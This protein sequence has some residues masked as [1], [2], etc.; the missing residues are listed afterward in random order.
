M[1][2]YPQEFRTQ[3]VISFMVIA[4]IGLVAG[5]DIL[6]SAIGIGQVI[7]STRIF[8]LH[9]GKPVSV[10]LAIQSITLIFKFLLFLASGILFLVWLNRANKNLASLQPLHVEFSSGWAVGWW[11]VPF[12]A[13][14]K[15][16]QVVRE[17]W[18]ESDPDRSGEQ[19]FLTSNLHSAPAYMG[20]WWA[21]WITTNILDNIA[22]RVFDAENLSVVKVTGLLFAA[23][24]ITSF[25]AG[26][27]AIFLVLDIT[28]RQNERFRRLYPAQPGYTPPPNLGKYGEI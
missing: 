11:F 21:A 27:L 28:K 1:T 9:N 24:G 13:L 15:P 26:A 17:V 18:W 14:I 4:A 23:A 10:W 5:F 3:K 20:F 7:D 25:V 12:A 6:S 22:F 16:F 8:H 19:T 2:N